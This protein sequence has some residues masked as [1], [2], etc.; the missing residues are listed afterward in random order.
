MH[1]N[2]REFTFD[3]D[4]PPLHRELDETPGLDFFDSGSALR[5]YVCGKIEWD[6]R[7]EQEF[8]ATSDGSASENDLHIYDPDEYDDWEEYEPDLDDTY[9]DDY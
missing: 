1:S 7:F 5:D 2:W 3:K 8:A 6:D 4:A 9:E